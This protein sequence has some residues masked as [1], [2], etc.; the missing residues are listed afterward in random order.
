[1]LCNYSALTRNEGRWLIQWAAWD[2]GFDKYLGTFTLDEIRKKV[3]KDRAWASIIQYQRAGT[4]LDDTA[5]VRD[6][7][8]LAGRDTIL[9]FHGFRIAPVR[10][11]DGQAEMC[12]PGE[13]TVWSIYGWHRDEENDC[14]GWMLVHDAD[15]GNDLAGKLAEITDLMGDAIE[16][17]DLEHAYANTGLATL[18]DLIAARILDEEPEG[19]RPDDA[20]RHPLAE[21]REQV[22]AAIAISTGRL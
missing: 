5:R 3:R 1:M 15:A 17:R 9:D 20:T 12:M 22:L 16:Y 2:A 14:A 4:R 21:L 13:H 6:F 10:I 7:N 8:G 18:A 11:T 19:A